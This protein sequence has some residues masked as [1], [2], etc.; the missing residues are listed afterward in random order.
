MKKKLF[1]I[2][3]RAAVCALLCICALL[4]T[5]CTAPEDSGKARIVC[6]TYVL[7]D[8]VT[9][10]L[11]EDADEWE[12]DLLG[13]NGADIHS[14]QPT[15]RDITKIA[16]CA[17]FI[18]VGG[19]SDSWVEGVLGSAANGN[20]TTLNLSEALKDHL[21][22]QHHAH[23]G[24][25][26]HGHE[27]GFDE[28]IWFSFDLVRE[29]ICE[30]ERALSHVKPDMAQTYS[31]NA[32][33]YTEKIAELETDYQKAAANAARDN[34]V[35]CDRFPFFYLTESLGIRHDAAYDGCS[36]ESEA[37]FSVVSR[38]SRVIDETGADCVLICE[39]SDGAIADAVIKATKNKNAK[40]LTLNSLQSVTQA[41]IDAGTSYLSLMRD[42]L[43]VLKEALS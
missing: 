38:L 5:G 16:K 8:W 29:C 14:Y 43:A 24:E 22:G 18:H 11:G 27:H 2:P 6:T 36:A 42:N 25:D 26:G 35:V 41:D 10:V 15:V 20:M 4:S 37:S 9:N 28:H 31:Q 40:V 34:I 32:Q 13:A 7:Y 23:E 3:C 33:S 19:E 12:I 39:S 30:I 1:N 21:C 17:L